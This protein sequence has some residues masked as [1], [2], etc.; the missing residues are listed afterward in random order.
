MSEHTSA[1][2][3]GRPPVAVSPFA[4]TWHE[5][6]HWLYLP[7]RMLEVGRAVL[8]P[9]NV[10]FARPAIESALHDAQEVLG[11]D[12]AYTYLT[13]RRGWSGPGNPI[14][15][16]G[17]HSDGFGTSDLN[18]VWTDR[19]ATQLACHDFGEISDDHEISLHQ[20]EERAR[21]TG[22]V[23]TGWLYR[24]DPSIIHRMNPDANGE[25]GMRSFLK[26]SFSQDRYDLLGNSHNHRFDYDWSMH[27]RDN[28]R[29]DPASDP[30]QPATS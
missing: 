25:G 10:Q 2:Q 19:C 5:L 7:V 24:F 23:D 14:N 8:L 9:E 29:N 11:Y 15:R 21:T 30:A 27:L 16:P 4:P 13:A 20:F 6:M 22:V 26:V 3:Y 18:Y 1:I 12:P 28:V 17:W